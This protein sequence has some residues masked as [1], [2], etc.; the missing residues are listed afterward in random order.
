MDLVAYQRAQAT[1]NELVP[2]ERPLALELL[3]DDER[4]EVVIVVACDAHRGI[5]EALGNQFF[6]FGGFHRLL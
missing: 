6:Y 4:F 2:R 1:V 3:G 5:G